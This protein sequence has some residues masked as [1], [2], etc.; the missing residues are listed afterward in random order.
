MSKGFWAFTVF[1]AVFFTVAGGGWA[2]GQ[3]DGP[4]EKFLLL[5]AARNAAKT[6]QYERSVHRYQRLLEKDPEFTQARTELGWVL[7]QAGKPDQARKQFKTVLVTHP[8]HAGAL[9]GLLEVLKKSG[10]KD[11]AFKVLAQLVRVLPEDRD[12]RMQ[13]AVELHNRGRYA[14]AEKHLNILL[15][16]DTDK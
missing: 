4:D 8:R 6:K 12:L 5:M 10:Q 2:L 16:Q 7:V 14:E 9:K 3:G 13:L 11:D 15:Q 1:T